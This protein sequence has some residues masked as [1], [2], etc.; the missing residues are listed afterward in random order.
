MLGL[1]TI[2]IGSLRKIWSLNGIDEPNRIIRFIDNDGI[3]RYGFIKDY[4]YNIWDSSPSQMK[5]LLAK[6]QIIEI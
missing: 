2:N 4:S 6:P 1:A 3:V 5:L